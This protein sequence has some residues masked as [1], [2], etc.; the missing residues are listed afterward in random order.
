MT[1]DPILL[2][3]IFPL[4]GI[5]LLLIM[6][7]FII[8]PRIADRVISLDLTISVGIG[9]AAAYTVLSGKQVVLDIA[10]IMALLAFLGTV[11]FAFYIER[12]GR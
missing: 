8:G 5:S 1:E 10:M 9:I 11:A 3:G 7:R 12:R 4:L 6:I 2:Y